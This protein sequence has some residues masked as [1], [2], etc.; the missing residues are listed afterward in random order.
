MEQ[1]DVSSGLLD[2]T[3]KSVVEDGNGNIWFSTTTHI[4]RYDARSHTFATFH[5]R[6]FTGSQFYDLISAAAGPDGKLYFGGSG[7][8]TVVDPQAELP[9]SREIPLRLESVIAGGQSQP[10]D[11]PSLRL[12]W[13]ENTLDVRAAGIDFNAGSLLNYAWK[14]DGYEKDW[15]YGSSPIHAIY[16]Y[17]PAGSYTFRARVR[18]QS[19]NWSPQEIT[20]PVRVLPSPWASPWAKLLYWLVGL[21]LLGAG[22]WFVIRIRTQEERLALAEQR[23]ELGRQHIDFVTNISHEFR[24]PLSMIYAPAKQLGKQDLGPEANDLVR[25]INRNADRLRNLSE[26]LLGSNGRQPGRERLTVRQNDLVSVVR[27]LASNFIYASSEKQQTLS[28]QLPET[29]LGWFDTEK[30]GKIVGNLLSNALKYTPEGGHILLRLDRDSSDAVLMVIDDGIGIPKDRRNRIFDRF[31]RL[32]AEESTVAGSGIGLNYAQKLARLHKGLISYTPNEPVGSVFTFR[33][34]VGHE[35]YSSD[36]IDDRTEFIPE[37]KLSSEADRRDLPMVLVA[38]DTDEIR[39]FLHSLLSPHY[40]VVLASDGMIALDSLKLSLPDLVLSDV[41]MPNI[42]GIGLCNAIKSNPD[43]AHLPVVLLTAKADAESSIEGMKTGADAYIPKPF[44]PDY[45]LA[46]IDSQ[47]ANRR[48]IQERILNLTSGSTEKAAALEEARLSPADK[49][50]LDR[51][52][53]LLDSHLESEGFNVAELAGEIGMSYSSLYA[54]IKA[55]T[56]KTPQAFMATYRMNIAMNLL[57]SGQYNVSEV[58]FRVGSSSPDT[59]SR[60]FKRHFGYPPSQVGKTN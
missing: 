51:I 58:A 55:L 59:F 23:E 52:H 54:K 5:D 3:I 2:N 6:H 38:E 31:D 27:S 32:G 20:L 13:N 50:L 11:S 24:T 40:R 41:I 16:S 14:L 39:R 26:Q 34:P 43:W 49:K 48:R 10:E 29:L 28:V 22:I 53:A 7:L 8:L 37:E 45:L 44:D 17:L 57:R 42:T 4:S 1:F 60:E 19:G 47:L 30:I 36:G 33:F 35:A 21:G 9:R 25:T 12:K 56:G 18:E 15:M 46:V